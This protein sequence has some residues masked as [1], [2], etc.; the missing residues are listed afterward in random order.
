[1]APIKEAMYERML[2][3]I[4]CGPFDGG[5]AVFA[6]ALQQVI[7]GEVLVGL[8]RRGQADHAVVA[9]ERML[10]DFDGPLP[11][12]E[13]TRRFLLNEGVV[14]IGFRTIEPGDLADSSRDSA[15][16][17]YLVA[18]LAQAEQSMPESSVV[19]RHR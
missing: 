19:P 9:Y 17:E 15:L 6:H 14:L 16:Q 7:G 10:W 18:L 5:C 2:N 4:Q 8:N 3:T 1:M 12:R 13:F 11:N